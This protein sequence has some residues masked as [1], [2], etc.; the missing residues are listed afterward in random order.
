MKQ[1]ATEWLISQLNTWQSITDEDT[2]QT[3]DIVRKLIEQAKEMEKWQITKAWCD[4]AMSIE[5]ENAEDYYNITF[6]Q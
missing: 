6:Q 3:L 5:E 4:G 2:N 1:T